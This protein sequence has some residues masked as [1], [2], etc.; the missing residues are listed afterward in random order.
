METRDSE[1]LGRTEAVLPL[2]LVGRGAAGVRVVPVQ[3][4]AVSKV[5]AGKAVSH[6]ERI[7]YHKS[8]NR[9]V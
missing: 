6:S 4:R 7:L 9:V 1:T 3:G 2:D 8:G 5:V